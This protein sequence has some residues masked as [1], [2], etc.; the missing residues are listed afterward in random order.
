MVYYYGLNKHYLALH[1]EC[2]GIRFTISKSYSRHSSHEVRE[3]LSI[4]QGNNGCG[5]NLVLRWK[6]IVLFTSPTDGVYRVSPFTKRDIQGLLRTANRLN[7][8]TLVALKN[9]NIYG[10]A[11]GYVFTGIAGSRLY[12]KNSIVA[13]VF[14]RD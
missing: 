7:G 14:L 10:I 3:S 1:A 5:C 6:H 8:L 9:I 12:L 2:E 11:Y 4:L 13:F